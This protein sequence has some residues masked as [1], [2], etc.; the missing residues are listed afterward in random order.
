MLIQEGERYIS[1]KTLQYF[2]Q[3]VKEIKESNGT[4]YKRS[5]LQ[6]YKGSEIIQGYLQIAF[7]PYKVYGISTKKL[8]KIVGGYGD[9]WVNSV[10]DLFEYLEEH[11]TGTDKDI[12]ICQEV[13]NNVSTYD[14]EAGELLQALICKDLSIGCDSKTINKEIP[15]CI[16]RFDVMLAQK[17]F[18]KPERIEGKTF[19]ITTKLDGF[20]LIAIKDSKGDV[21]FYSRVGQPVEGLVEIEAEL[22]E[23]FPNNFA[24][25]GELT[26]S[27]YFDLPSKEAY[28]AASKIIRL[29]GDTPKTGLTYRVFDCMSAHEFMQQKCDKTYFERR[30]TLDTFDGVAPH[31]EVLPVLYQGD[32][33]SKITEWLDKVV[34]DSGEGVMLNIL[35]EKY[36]WSRSWAIQKVKKFDSLDLEVVGVEEGSGRLSGTLGAIHVRYKGGNI[37][38]VGSGFSDE[39]RKL[40]WEHPELIVNKIVEVKFFESTKNSSGEESLR[41]PTWCSNIRIDKLTP[42]F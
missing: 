38:K 2:N 41:F 12:S 21:K 7:D 35:S 28:K 14:R 6:K 4:Y 13:L 8:S 27:N 32:D 34:A 30:A 22:K 36:S 37:V 20:R 26:I 23:H 5:V 33:T 3:F 19:A 15:N 16:P 10:F 24:L 11:N 17:Y 9:C 29:K 39:E 18:D 40:Y 31:V 42:D 25:D 1:M